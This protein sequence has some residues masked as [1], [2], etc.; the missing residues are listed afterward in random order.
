MIRLGAWILC[1]ARMVL[2]VMV[3]HT[4]VAA[5]AAAQVSDIGRFF[6][7]RPTGFVRDVAGLIDSVTH[8]QV[9]ARLSRL[10]ART[11]GEIAVVT[12][13]TIGDQAP[14]AVATQIGRT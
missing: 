13:A 4:C 7:G 2:T 12:L 8:A 10:R 1:I 9:E 14:A 11:G 6:P 5:T 3:L